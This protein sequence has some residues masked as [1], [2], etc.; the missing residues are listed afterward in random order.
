VIQK[1]TVRGIGD[2][3]SPRETIVLL[4]NRL[5]LDLPIGHR[6]DRRLPLELRLQALHKAYQ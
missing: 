6:A 2:D 4:A 1:L 3:N 5:C